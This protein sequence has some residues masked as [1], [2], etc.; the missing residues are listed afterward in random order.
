MSTRGK[1]KWSLEFGGASYQEGLIS[2]SGAFSAT[3]VYDN[4]MN[5]AGKGT[6]STRLRLQPGGRLELAPSIEADFRLTD[7]T[8]RTETSHDSTSETRT[9]TWTKTTRGP[10]P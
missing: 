8:G 3:L 6:H 5:G 10:T 7:P 9:G 1:H 2:G 4:G